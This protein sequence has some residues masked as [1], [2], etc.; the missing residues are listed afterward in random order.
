VTSAQFR[1]D[2]ENDYAEMKLVLADL[3]L[4]KR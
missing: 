3:G 1:K 2:L 4:A